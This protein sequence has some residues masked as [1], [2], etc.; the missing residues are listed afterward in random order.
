MLVPW[1]NSY[2]QPI[3]HIKKQRQSPSGQSYGFSCCHIWMWELD[4]KESWAQKNWCFWT[5]VLEKTLE[6]PLNCKGIQ[7]VHANKIS[8]EYSLEGLMLRLKLQSSVHLMWRADS[9]EKTLMHGKIEGRR[10]RRRQRMRWMDGIT[11]SM[12]R[13]LITIRSSNDGQGDL[14]C[15]S[16]GLKESDMTEWLNWTECDDLLY[17]NF[18]GI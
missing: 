3:Q 11:G 7:L 15:C 10:R 13:S 16:W 17:V 8:P 12:D 2:D 1:K 9:F 6:I 14:V 18:W 5:V 4:C